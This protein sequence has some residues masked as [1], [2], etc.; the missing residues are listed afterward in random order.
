M[1]LRNV[2]DRL[3]PQFRSGGRH[4]RWQPLFD[5]VDTFFYSPGTVTQGA[6]HVRDGIDARRVMLMVWLCALPAA[7]FGVYNVGRQALARMAQQGIAP[8]D[9][10]RQW[11]IALVSD[12]NPASIWD[13]L[14]YGLWF[15][16]P[17]Y[18]VCLLAAVGCEAIFALAR[19]RPLAE[20]TLVTALLFALICPP[21]VPLWM[22]ALGT[23]FGVVVGQE[24]LGRAGRHWLN[25]VLLGY[26]VLLLVFPVT[27]GGA[28]AGL[29]L[30]GRTG[31]TALAVVQADSLQLL[32]EQLSWRDALFGARPGAIGETATLAVAVGGAVLLWT[33]IAAW[34]V[35]AGALLGMVILSSLCNWIGP[36]VNPLFAMPW[37]WHLVTGGFAFGV[38][39]LATDPRSA[40]ITNAGRWWYGLLIGAAVVLWRVFGFEGTAFAILLANL[41][42][43]LIDRGVVR[44]HIKRRLARR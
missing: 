35:V 42:A 16:L 36:T 2:L 29:A 14:W 40:A 8:N 9:D 20:G 37:Y 18:A 31:A 38:L 1:G 24:L 5:A 13:C 19:R 4:A 15:F 30:D 6:V 3:E 23:A 43:P 39:F 22:A 10:W 34:R 21:T 26:A 33:G 27:M 28:A 11:F 7:A 12:Y 32:K 41:L 17:L 25:P 44:A